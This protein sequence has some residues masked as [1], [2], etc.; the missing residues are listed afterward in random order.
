MFM[1]FSL[2]KLYMG[3]F[4]SE[5]FLWFLRAGETIA[6]Q[7]CFESQMVSQKVKKFVKTGILYLF[8]FLHPSPQ[9]NLQAQPAVNSAK[10]N[11]HFDALP[12]LFNGAVQDY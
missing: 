12:C 7:I 11:G 1:L 9:K 3:L 10:C 8:P 5:F 2:M 6:M 4:L